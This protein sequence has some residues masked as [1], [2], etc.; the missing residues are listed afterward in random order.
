MGTPAIGLV[1]G[2]ATHEWSDRLGK[3]FSNLVSLRRLPGVG[4]F[5]PS[6]APEEALQAVREA[7]EASFE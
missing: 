3:F 4:H 5:V 1:V 6:E 7:R 2:F